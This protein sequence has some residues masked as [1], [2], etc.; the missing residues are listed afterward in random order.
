MISAGTEESFG[1]KNRSKPKSLLLKEHVDEQKE[2]YSTVSTYLQKQQ[3]SQ[4]E[5]SE[6][7]KKIHR[8]IDRLAD[9]QKRAYKEMTR[10]NE[11]IEQLKLEKLKMEILKLKQH[12]LK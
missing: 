1:T 2:F 10:H 3:Q 6:D 11:A 12:K 4:S 7:I 5:N 8:S 9:N